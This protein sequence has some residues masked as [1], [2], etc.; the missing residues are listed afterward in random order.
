MFHPLSA[1][2]ARKAGSP[3]LAMFSQCR[4]APDASSL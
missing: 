4:L 3:L 1:E 2:P